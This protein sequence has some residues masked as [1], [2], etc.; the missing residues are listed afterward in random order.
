[1]LVIPTNLPAGRYSIHVTAEDIAHNVS[2]QEV[3]IE[4]VP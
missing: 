2:H 1:M 3:P 4:V